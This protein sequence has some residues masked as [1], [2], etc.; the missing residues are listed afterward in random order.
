MKSGR[1]LLVLAFLYAL[2][3]DFWLWQRPEIV[4]GLPIE[5]WYQ[6]TYCVLVALIL[7]LLLRQSWFQDQDIG[8][9]DSTDP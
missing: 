5:L 7:A 4:M 1:V 2:H 6:L 9:P 8:S 3:Y